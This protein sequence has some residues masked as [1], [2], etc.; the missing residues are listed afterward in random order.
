[1]AYTGT[2]DNDTCR[3]WF[4]KES[5]KDFIKEYLNVKN[6]DDVTEAMVRAVLSSASCLA[7]IPIQDFLD[8]PGR[9]NTPS[10]L[11]TDN[12]SFRITKDLLSSKNAE[13]IRHLTSIYK[14]I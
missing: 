13:K 7:I 2:H 1:M 12:W 14:R 3:G 10:T 5:N 11:N 6:D 8:I 4:E 9:M